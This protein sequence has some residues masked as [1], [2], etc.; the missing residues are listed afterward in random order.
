MAA[1]MLGG[2]ADRYGTTQFNDHSTDIY[3]P[4]GKNEFM[5]VQK[6]NKADYTTFCKTNN[7][8]SCE[9]LPYD[10]YVG[11]RGFFSNGSVIKTPH[12]DFVEIR[13]Q[14]GERL[15]FDVTGS[16]TVYGDKSQLQSVDEYKAIERA[17]NQAVEGRIRAENEKRR[18]QERVAEIARQKEEEKRKAQQA[19]DRKY[20]MKSEPLVPGSSIMLVEK[21]DVISKLDGYKLSNGEEYLESFIERVREVSKKFSNREAVAEH[22]LGVGY[23]K[24]EE[25]EDMYFIDPHRDRKSHFNLGFTISGNKAYPRF[26]VQYLGYDWIFANHYILKADN[27]KWTYSSQTFDHSNTAYDVKEWSQRVANA[28]DIDRIRQLVT[29]KKAMVKISGKYS[30]T[31][32]LDKDTIEDLKWGIRFYELTR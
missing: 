31:F 24:H 6:D 19:H 25:F 15:Y 4:S 23:I 18:Q 1:A 3:Y 29:A 32:E 13:L 16:I 2:C 22:L 11:M 27:R 5:F 26:Y 7:I 9:P 20:G 10:T 28:S 12:G 8:R 21:A 30:D 17:K 14:S